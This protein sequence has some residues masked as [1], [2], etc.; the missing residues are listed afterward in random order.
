[1][2]PSAALAWAQT[3]TG[4]GIRNNLTRDLALQWLQ[5]DRTA[6]QEWIANSKLPEQMKSELLHR[7]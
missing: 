1:L 5:R 2:T 7:P 3:I 4:D 6:A